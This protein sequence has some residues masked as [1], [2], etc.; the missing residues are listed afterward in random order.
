MKRNACKRKTD[1]KQK[2]E[3]I[4]KSEGVANCFSSHISIILAKTAQPCRWKAYERWFCGRKPRRPNE[5]PDNDTIC[6]WGNTEVT[7][8]TIAS[9]SM[10][11]SAV[12][13]RQSS[14]AETGCPPRPSKEDV[15]SARTLIMLSA[16]FFRTCVNCFRLHIFVY[17][18]SSAF[19]W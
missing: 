18:F 5:V 1:G 9:M 8:N 7:Y 2:T 19:L 14:A 3:H 10:N 17:T 12:E 6:R 16:Y 15:R 4:E 11:H 13:E